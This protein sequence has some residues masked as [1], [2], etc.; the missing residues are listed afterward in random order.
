MPLG[1]S[2]ISTRRFLEASVL[3][4][5]AP[6]RSLG[7]VVDTAQEV[8]KDGV[9]CVAPIHLPLMRDGSS[10]LQVPP[11]PLSTAAVWSTRFLSRS[12]PRRDLPLGASLESM[13]PTRTTSKLGLP[14]SNGYNCSMSTR[15]PQLLTRALSFG[16][17]ISPKCRMVAAKFTVMLVDALPDPPLLSVTVAVIL[18]C[19]DCGRLRSPSLKA[20]ELESN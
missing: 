15:L 4:M 10:E 18:T 17:R 20:T 14:A 3:S 5:A 13:W 8:G 9:S 6:L 1:T 16:N 2:Q 11:P 12:R 7:A 19:L